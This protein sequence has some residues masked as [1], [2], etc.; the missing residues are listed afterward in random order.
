VGQVVSKE[1][2]PYLALHTP[3][4]QRKLLKDLKS[5]ETLKIQEPLSR[6][7]GSLKSKATKLSGSSF[8]CLWIPWEVV[9]ER[10]L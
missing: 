8:K 7:D 1:N 9:N 10:Y 4:V 3:T 6:F 2:K 5:Y